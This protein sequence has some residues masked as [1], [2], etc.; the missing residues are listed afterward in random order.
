MGLT[1]VRSW[2]LHL[3]INNAGVN[4]DQRTITGDG[5]ETNWAVNY[6]APFLLTQLLLDRLTAGAPARVVNLGT[7]IQPAIDLDDLLREKSYQAGMAYTQSKTG[8]VLF[9]RELARRLAGTRVTVNC[10]NPGLVHTQLGRDARGGFRVFLALMRPIMKSPEQAARDILY[11]AT[12][13]S[14]SRCAPRGSI[15]A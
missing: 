10:I 11:L 2:I 6:L 4:P 13:P 3:L 15:K 12:S 9:T 7:W 8:V 5:F 14:Q 1:L